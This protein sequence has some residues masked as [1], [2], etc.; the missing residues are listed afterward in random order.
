MS[1]TLYETHVKVILLSWL[2]AFFLWVAHIKY[3]EKPICEYMVQLL[4]VMW[5]FMME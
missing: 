4:F 1:G 3:K 2:E 5:Y